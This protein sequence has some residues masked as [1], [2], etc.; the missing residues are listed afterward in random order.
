MVFFVMVCTFWNDDMNKHIQYR[1]RTYELEHLIINSL[2]IGESPSSL[3]LARSTTNIVNFFFFLDMGLGK[4]LQS[5]C[6]MAA[7]Y[8]NMLKKFKVIFF[9]LKLL[10]KIV[11]NCTM[12][13]PILVVMFILKLLKSNL[14]LET[15]DFR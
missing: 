11:K 15:S 2:V 14:L 10:S 7:D 1:H 4:T 3:R 13:L 6:I 8:H 9:C 12:R 5:I